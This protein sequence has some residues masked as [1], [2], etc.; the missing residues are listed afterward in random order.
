MPRMPRIATAA[1]DL[2]SAPILQSVGERDRLGRTRRRLADGIPLR[3]PQFG[4][5]IP[6]FEFMSFGWP[7]SRSG[8][9]TPH[10]A[11]EGLRHSPCPGNF[12]LH[13]SDRAGLRRR[14]LTNRF[15]RPNLQQIK[16][17]Q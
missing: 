15:Y 14:L 17:I 4:A 11:S 10:S 9:R 16:G 12:S 3:T 13:I 1:K 5:P 2:L 6:L 8:F 7:D